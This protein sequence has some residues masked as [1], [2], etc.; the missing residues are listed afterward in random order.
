MLTYGALFA[1]YGGLEIGVQSVLGGR[2][3]WHSENAPAP[4][5]VFAHHWPDAPNLGDIREIEWRDVEP[6]D[7]ITGGF[8]CQDVSHAGRVLG[9]RPDT[10][11]GVWSYMAYAIGQLRPQLV[12]I[13]NVKGLLSASAVRHVEPCPVCLDHAG[14]RPLR[15]LGAV[16][17]DLAGLGYHTWWNRVRASDAGAPHERL[18]VFIFAAR[19]AADAEPVPHDQPGEPGRMARPTGRSASPHRHPARDGAADGGPLDHRRGADDSGR[20]RPASVVWGPYAQAVER[21]ADVIGRPAP[22]P[23]DPDGDLEPGF[24][25]WL[26]G[27]DVGHVTDPAI[28]LSAGQQRKTLGNGVVPQQAALATRQ[29][30][31]WKWAA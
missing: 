31:E 24:V 30:L 27:L 29:W 9:M 28:G 7:V 2:T 21:W 13:E 17:G 4:A 20:H 5:A 15:A 25:E 19:A 22:A 18:R 26:M 23:T 8:P 14:A 16:L 6:V 1:G 11:S 12:V 10:R 3:L